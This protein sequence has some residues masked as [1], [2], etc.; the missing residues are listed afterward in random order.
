[1]KISKDFTFKKCCF[2]S[3][4][5]HYGMWLITEVKCFT[6]KALGHYEILEYFLVVKFHAHLLTAVEKYGVQANKKYTKISSEN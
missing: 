6:A 2:I 5:I 4:M 1:V 3:L